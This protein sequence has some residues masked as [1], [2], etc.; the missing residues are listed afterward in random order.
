MPSKSFKNYHKNLKSVY[1]LIEAHDI[2]KGSDK[3]KKAIDHFTKSI[4]LMLSASW[5][6]YIEEVV[7]ESVT[8]LTNKIDDPNSLPE[9][10]KTFFVEYVKGDNSRVL[11]FAGSGWKDLLI[12]CATLEALGDDS[13]GKWGLNTPKPHIINL[14]FEKLL[15]Y[16]EPLSKDWRY[17]QDEIRKFIELRGIFA[18][19]GRTDEYYKIN[20]AKNLLVVVNQTV[21]DTDISLMEHLHYYT[22]K[23]P[24]NYTYNK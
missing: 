2:V 16:E 15:G 17:S 5:E 14:L 23:Q 13:Q 21:R 7:L 22:Y 24:W 9:K 19:N 12:E 20:I 11:R 18:H 1:R 10:V 6:S 3:G 4:I 8:F